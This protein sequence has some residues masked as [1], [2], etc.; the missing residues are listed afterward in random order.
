MHKCK[1]LLPSD[2]SGGLQCL[3]KG[4]VPGLEHFQN[5]EVLF[6]AGLEMPRYSIGTE[7]SNLPLPLLMSFPRLYFAAHLKQNPWGEGETAGS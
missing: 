1:P 7:M 3:Q 2:S 6:E 5:P 4:F